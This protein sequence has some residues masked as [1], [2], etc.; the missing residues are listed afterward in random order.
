MGKHD[1]QQAHFSWNPAPDDFYKARISVL[2]KENLK[3]HER[4]RELEMALGNMELVVEHGENVSDG[5]NN[6]LKDIIAEKDAEIETLQEA[7]LNAVTKLGW[8]MK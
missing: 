2:E 6:E 8:E 3:L 7:L 5:I 4:V 1:K